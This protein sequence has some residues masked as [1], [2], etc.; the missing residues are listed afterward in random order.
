MIA[1]V[2]KPATA[3]PNKAMVLPPGVVCLEGELHCSLR[4]EDGVLRAPDSE[5]TRPSLVQTDHLQVSLPFLALPAPPFAPKFVLTHAFDCCLPLFPRS[6]FDHICLRNLPNCNLKP[7]IFVPGSIT[8]LHLATSC[9]NFFDLHWPLFDYLSC[10]GWPLITPP[11]PFVCHSIWMNASCDDSIP[12]KVMRTLG[13]AMSS[14]APILLS[15][16]SGSGKTALLMELAAQMGQREGLVR[17][18]MDEQIDSKARA[19]FDLDGVLV[20]IDLD[21]LG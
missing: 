17:I 2:G 16:P 5:S 7:F 21:G 1:Q 11:L 6:S 13:I 12:Q 14:G 4:L 9:S 3:K 19:T 15:G 10:Y 8:M 18:H 20:Q